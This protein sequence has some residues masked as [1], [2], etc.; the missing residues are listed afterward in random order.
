MFIYFADDI[1]SSRPRPSD[2]ATGAPSRLLCTQHQGKDCAWQRKDLQGTHNST[3]IAYLIDFH[4]L[5]PCF[6][7]NKLVKSRL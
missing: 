5:L 2:I 4:L 6:I 7:V 3:H 1:R